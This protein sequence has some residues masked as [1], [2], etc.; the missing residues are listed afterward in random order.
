MSLSYLLRRLGTLLLVLVGVSI[1]TFAIIPLIP[2]SPARVMLGVQATPATVATLE[3]QMGL[4]RP[5]PVQ[6]LSWVSGIVTRGDFGTSL[7]SRQPISRE[8]ARRL[9]ATLNLAVVALLIG[10]AIALPAGFVSAMK[11]GSARDLGVSIMSQL[12]VSV[13]DFWMGILLILLFSETLGLLPSSGYRPLSDGFV[14]WARHIILP[15]LTV[16]II[17]GSIMARFVRSALLEVLHQD[18]V[19]TAHAKGLPGAVVLRKHVL[20]NAAISIATIVGLQMAT[21]LSAVVVVEIIFAWPGLGQLALTATLQRDY[22]ALQAAVL[23]SAVAFAVVN[24]LTDL[25]YMFL[26]PRVAYD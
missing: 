20:R 8:V 11:P 24:L 2:G 22:P 16:G 7:I 12:G 10:L 18:Y 6:Y 21:L 19:R 4:D 23:L 17:S 3:R 14:P 13:P 26:D 15:A 25:S 9:P 5:L 1:L